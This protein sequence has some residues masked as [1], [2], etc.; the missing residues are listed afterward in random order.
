MGQGH[1]WRIRM[2]IL[3]KQHI[4][5]IDRQAKRM[6]LQVADRDVITRDMVVDGPFRPLSERLI[7]QE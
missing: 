7:D 3:S 5:E 2:K 4:V 1:Y 6:Q